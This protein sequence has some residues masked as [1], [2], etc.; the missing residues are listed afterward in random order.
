MFHPASILW[1]AT[2]SFFFA[3]LTAHIMESLIMS[4]LSEAGGLSL[5]IA[6]IVAIMIVIIAG[7]LRMLY[8]QIM[9][10]LD[11]KIE[12]VSVFTKDKFDLLMEKIKESE[13]HIDNYI[14]RWELR[15]AKFE[16]QLHQVVMARHEMQAQVRT[17]MTRLDTIDAS[18]EQVSVRLEKGFLQIESELRNLQQVRGD[19]Q[20]RLEV[21]YQKLED[22]ERRRGEYAA[23]LE[24]KFRVIE[25]EL[26][27]IR[28]TKEE[29]VHLSARI[30]YLEDSKR[31][32]KNAVG[33]A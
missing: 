32:T 26:Y 31:G 13:I 8:S 9:R 25:T 12:R 10:G 4:A 14:S 6:A 30:R 2:V 17:I 22:Q 7:M 3:Y 27:Q 33:D 1:L 20:T 21:L 19:M 18:R 28:S 23:K 16:D 11:D 5:G 24:E 29:L 15:T